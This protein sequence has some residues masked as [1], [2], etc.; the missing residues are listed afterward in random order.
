MSVTLEVVEPPRVP[1]LYFWA[2]QVDVARTPLPLG[3]PDRVGGAHLGLQWHPSHPG[4]TAV[5]WG[6]YA[7]SGGELDGSASELP[8]ATANPN[9][10]DLP[11]RPRVPYRLVISRVGGPSGASAWRGSVTDLSTGART[12]VRDLHM[13]A[14][15]VAGVTM[16]SEVFADC[17]AP[18]TS[19]RWSEP[20]GVDVGG[21]TVSPTGVVVGYQSEADGG[22]SNTD[23]SADE[24]GFVQR[25]TSRRVSA[26]GAFLPIR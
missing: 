23:S 8:S 26:A 1:S 14:G 13:D 10:R 15:A 17:G 6:G 9:T 24:G 5:N 22:C 4:S 21:A 25:T 7:H 19:V 11:W 3:T 16:W 2:L 18:A 12:T 20:L